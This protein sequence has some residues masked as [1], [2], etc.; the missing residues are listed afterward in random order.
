MSKAK[1]FI[2]ALSREISNYNNPEQA[3]SQANSCDSLS[4]DI[5]TDSKRFIY[6]LLQNA[7]DASSQNGKLDVRIDF[8]GNYLVVS[9]Q[10]EPFSEIDIKSIC[11][12]GDG[13]KKGDENKTGFKGIG[14]KSVFTHSEQVIIK[15]RDYCFMFD[16]N[17][18]TKWN[19]AWENEA[20]WMA[21]RRA[22]GKDDAIKM[23]WQIIPLWTELPQE[24][25]SLSTLG[26]YN[27]ATII[28]PHDIELLKASL[29]ELFE[30]S[31][32]ALF[33]RNKDVKVSIYADKTLEIEKTSHKDISTLK[34]NGKIVSEW[35]I[36][37]ERFEVPQEVRK[38]ICS[39]NRY[40]RKLREVQ[41]TEIS[42]AIQ[43]KNG[44]LKAADKDKQY[45]F[46][47]LPTSIN[48]G[49]PFLVNGNFL[50]DAGRE[51]IHKDLEWNQWLFKQ[52]PLR[53]FAWVAELAAKDSCYNRQIFN[54]IPQKL[55]G[56][57]N[58]LIAKFNEGFSEAIRTIAFI[59]NLQGDLLRVNEVLFDNSQI[60]QALSHDTLASYINNEH[61]TH[62][63]E[64]SFVPG[65]AL[66][67]RVLKSLGVRIFDV[68]DLNEFFASEIF[69]QKHLLSE[70]FNLITFLHQQTKAD[71]DD[72]W[73]VK[74]QHMTFLFDEKGK[75]CSPQEIYFPAVKFSSE[76]SDDISVIAAE[77]LEKIN[78]NEEIKL[79]LEELGV[80]E[81]TDI[82]FINK[83]IIGDKNYITKEN[84]VTIGRYL[85][86][87]HKKGLL[88]SCSRLSSVKLLTQDGELK[89]ANACFLS[90]AYES[91]LRLEQVTDIDMF[92]SESYLASDDLKSE[93]KTFF[94]KMGVNDDVSWSYQRVEFDYASNPLWKKR[95][96]S[97]Y[98][99]KV[100]E[101]SK[102]WGWVSNEGWSKENRNY[103][104][105]IDS[106]SFTGLPF[107]EHATNYGFSKMFFNQILKSKA[108]ELKDE[109]VTKGMTGFISRYLSLNKSDLPD[110]ADLHPTKWVLNNLS[111]IPTTQKVCKRA[112]DV[113]AT[114]IPK[115]NELAGKYLPVLDYDGAP[116]PE[117]SQI[118]RLKEQLKLED[119]LSILSQI[120]NDSAANDDETKEN[121]TRVFLI[122]EK[123]AELLPTLHEYECETL[124]SQAN[125]NRL[126]AN[127]G[128]FYLPSELS[129]VSVDGFKAN[130]LIYANGQVDEA[131]LTLWEL[132]GVKI[133][134]KV[135]ATFS[136]GMIRQDSLRTQLQ[137]IAP[138]I[139]LVSV[140]K[141]KNKKDWEKEYARINDLLSD[142]SFFETTEIHL[143]YGND[144]DQQQRSTHSDGNKFYYVGNW[145]KPRVLDGLTDP[146]CK[147]LKISYASRCLNVLLSD[148]Y[149]EG[150]KYL[151]ENGYDTSLIPTQL[152]VKDM[153]AIPNQNNR[154]Y[155]QSDA[156]LG[157]KGEL[158]VFEQLKEIYTAKYHLP[159]EDTEDGCRIA[160][161][162][163]ILWRNKF[164]NTMADH[165]F[166]I[167]EG[168]YEIYIDCKAT[169]Y[170]KNTEKLAL[171]ISGSELNLME[172]AEKY[173]IA[174]VYDAFSDSPSIEFV[175]LNLEDM[176]N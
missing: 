18:G 6:E 38:Q 35:L 163:E 160:D 21:R 138:L 79:W 102:E 70:N 61:S 10:G 14:F 171:Y 53:Y 97:A 80:Q 129:H 12:V 36:K 150:L 104:Y 11:S 2:E 8:V 166:K 67:Y 29:F 37:T 44:Q 103:L 23:P 124:K 111:V 141:S 43:L 118:L 51:N 108:P 69:L 168:E 123:L 90:D 54:V 87:A 47:Y 76:F 140:E 100:F 145:Y 169:S 144:D 5:Y 117:W 125:S 20:D 116:S 49:L 120:A 85:F 99:T 172:R 162:V 143:S 149:T 7:D 139:A 25:S 65:H 30:E 19:P 154:A 24:L 63:S 157:S 83:T 114:S 68:E 130:K 17:K 48:Y 115:I 142:I 32:I 153:E 41:N 106:I 31:Q 88:T 91:S 155:N 134:N 159:M 113:Y 161:R 26:N 109:V 165:D 81:P 135:S 137:A 131:I 16:K 105:N 94:L 128:A 77:V 119:Y 173:L 55:E 122:Y 147:Y 50:T 27:V 148:K 176:T 174:R 71:K 52:I 98:L 167:T 95:F 132:W 4:S 164:A 93:W 78:E 151:E 9:H 72:K 92:V 33:L 60:S 57:D 28:R 39:N 112:T 158:I 156:D 82:S 89:S 62:F 175:R 121:K 46:T 107:L 15:S 127:D 146:L 96:D 136:S 86:K 58:G 75:L 73:N 42:F 170:G 34:C 84:A 101:V 1:N 45:I 56:H 66:G 13:N 59:P 3:I 22:D 40:P 64:S 133:I 126:L 110:L 152:E 74:L